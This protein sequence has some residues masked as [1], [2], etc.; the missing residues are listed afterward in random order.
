MSDGEIPPGKLRLID[1]HPSHVLVGGPFEG[2][3][4]LKRIH[5]L[6]AHGDVLLAHPGV[7]SPVLQSE[8]PQGDGV[9][10]QEAVLELDTGTGKGHVQQRAPARVEDAVVHPRILDRPHHDLLEVGVDEEERPEA[11]LLQAPDATVP[12]G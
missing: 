5:D 7:I 8:Q 6:L 2:L 11:L 10:P 4:L 1:S 3:E 12:V 9:P